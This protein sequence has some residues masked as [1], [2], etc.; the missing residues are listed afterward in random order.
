MAT[1][2]V[3]LELKQKEAYKFRMSCIML[4][5]VG[6]LRNVIWHFNL[7]YSNSKMPI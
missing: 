6:S 3:H 5:E 7:K 1:A 4:K 2:N